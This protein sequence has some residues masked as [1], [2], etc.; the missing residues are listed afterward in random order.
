MTVL[1]M[2]TLTLALALAVGCRSSASLDI[3]NQLVKNDTQDTAAPED[4]APPEDTGPVDA[5]ENGFSAA[6]DCD[7]TDPAVHPG[8]QEA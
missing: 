1:P 3:E 2:R 4:K 7:D 8:A 6:D 5:D